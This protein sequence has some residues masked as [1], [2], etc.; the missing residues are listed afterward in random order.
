MKSVWKS[1]PNSAIGWISSAR[2][3]EMDGN[4][5]EAWNIIGQACDRFPTNDSV[6]IEASW[7]APPAE[8]KQILLKALSNNPK[9]KKLWLEAAS[10][11]E[12]NEAKRKILWRALE[13][14]SND[15]ELW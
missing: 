3:E 14:V 12:D 1:N 2:V 7:L 11:E 6:W 5:E 4:I 15:V 10:K 13:Y 9:S 8:S